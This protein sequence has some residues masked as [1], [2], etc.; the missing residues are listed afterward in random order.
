MAC[1]ALHN[2][3][4]ADDMAIFGAEEPLRDAMAHHQQL[5]LIRNEIELGK[6]R[7]EEVATL[8]YQN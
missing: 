8:L 6:T 4:N 5:E 2:I 7:R 1:F 3:A